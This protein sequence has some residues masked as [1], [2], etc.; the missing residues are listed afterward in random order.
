MVRKRME[1]GLRCSYQYNE[2]VSDN[3]EKIAVAGTG[4]ALVVLWAGAVLEPTPADEATA[5][6]AT[7]K[8]LE[9]GSR[10]FAGG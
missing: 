8:Y 1:L 7:A 6:A 5:A 4:V 9:W 10:V 2:L 3:G